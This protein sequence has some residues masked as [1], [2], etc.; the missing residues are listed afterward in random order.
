M[1]ELQLPDWA[2][3]KAICIVKKNL[4]C[5]YT[6][7]GT[8]YRLYGPDAN[9]MNWSVGIPITD[10][11]SADQA[12][13]ETN[14]MSAFNWPIGQRPYAF[15]TSD[16]QFNGDGVTF[17]ATAGTTTNCDYKVLAA[18]Q[19]GL[20]INGGDIFTSGSVVGDYIEVQAVD[21]DN[22]L[23]YGA[24][25]V[26]NTWVVKWYISPAGYQTVMTPYAGL[27][28]GGVYLRMIYHSV[29]SSP[30]TV[31]VNYRLHLPI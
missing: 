21:V 5:Q 3:F 20:N 1:T 18:G 27:I 26:L 10:P 13:F 24:N 31:A 2:T 25:T 8:T 23:G 9:D 11:P 4:N 19:K 15:A 14:Y 17:I 29:G 28:P 22:L 30:V 12:D 16:F 6:S 7:D